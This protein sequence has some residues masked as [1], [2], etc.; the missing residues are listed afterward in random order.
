ME[1]RLAA[2]W[3]ELFAKSRILI[4][5]DFFE[6]G[7]HSLLA[8][9]LMTVLRKEEWT[10]HAAMADVYQVRVCAQRERLVEQQSLR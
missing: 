9:R 10:S 7:G 6:L 4:N 2:V 3:R 1:I 8:A 5:D